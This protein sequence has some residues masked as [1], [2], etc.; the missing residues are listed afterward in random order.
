VNAQGALE[1]YSAAVAADPMR[2]F[3]LRCRGLFKLQNGDLQVIQFTT[4]HIGPVGHCRLKT[5]APDGHPDCVPALCLLLSLPNANV[6]QLRCALPCRGLRYVLQGLVSI[7][8]QLCLA[9]DMYWH[10]VDRPNRASKSRAVVVVWQ[11]LHPAS[12]FRK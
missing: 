9:H 1:D 8:D 6:W 12:C 2:P 4:Q 10:S 3:A 5:P 7:P 11:R